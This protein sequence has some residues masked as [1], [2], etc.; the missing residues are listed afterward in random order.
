MDE[1]LHARGGGV[2]SP[3]LDRK[4]HLIPYLDGRQLPPQGY[5]LVDLD[6]QLFWVDPVNVG[7]SNIQPWHTLT[8]SQTDR[9]F[10]YYKVLSEHMPSTRERV[11]FDLEREPIPE[12]ELRLW[13]RMAQVYILEIKRRPRA[14]K[15]ERTMLWAAILTSLSSARLEHVISAVPFTKNLPDIERVVRTM[16]EYGIAYVMQTKLRMDLRLIKHYADAVEP[17]LINN[18]PAI[19]LALRQQIMKLSETERMD[20][21]ALSSDPATML[22]DTFTHTLRTS[23]FIAAYALFESVLVQLCKI[24]EQLPGYPPFLSNRKG[25]GLRESKEYLKRA[26]FRFPAAINEWRKLQFYKSIRNYIL[27]ADSKLDTSKNASELREFI[28]K[29][30]IGSISKDGRLSLNRNAVH[31]ISAVIDRFGIALRRALERG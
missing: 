27:H 22:N 3:K 14:Q 18:L 30:K 8:E 23:T 15:I 5:M 17:I 2:G 9:V 12:R 11:I 16:A 7:V 24:F 13:E 1:P 10:A 25:D 28:D 4:T 6:G 19:S 26:K 20:F 29:E 31:D 21:E